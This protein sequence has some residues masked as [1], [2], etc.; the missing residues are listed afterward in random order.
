MKEICILEVGMLKQQKSNSGYKEGKTS[1]FTHLFPILF[2][3]LFRVKISLCSDKK[4]YFKFRAWE[5]EKRRK[6]M[7]NEQGFSKND[8]ELREE[9]VVGDPH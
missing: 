2:K 5:R 7:E 6:K 1:V 4:N 3:D 9:F 8:N